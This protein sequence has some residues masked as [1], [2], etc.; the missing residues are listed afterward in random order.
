MNCVN[1]T[2]PYTIVRIGEHNVSEFFNQK[3][4]SETELFPDINVPHTSTPLSIDHPPEKSKARQY[5]L[6]PYLIENSMPEIIVV[7]PFRLSERSTIQ[8]GVFLMPGDIS[9]PFE[10]NISKFDRK[11]DRL[12]RIEIPIVPEIRK[13]FL[14]HLH[15]MNISRATLFPGLQGYAES[16]NARLALPEVLSY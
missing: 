13:E 2:S 14:L 10:E 7:N 11:F 4:L 5:L 3:K 8:Q 12:T 9:I 1:Y 6:I 15:R 16:L